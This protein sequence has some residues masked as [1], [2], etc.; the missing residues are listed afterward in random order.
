MSFTF[1]L[2]TL[3]PAAPTLVEKVEQ[4]RKCPADKNQQL[5]REEM[6]TLEEK[7]VKLPGLSVTGSWAFVKPRDF[8]TLQPPAHRGAQGL[9]HI[10]KHAEA[11]ESLNKELNMVKSHYQSSCLLFRIPFSTL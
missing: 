3:R 9:S 5:Y 11:A 2:V 6:Q 1:L 8:L 10:A 7:P 4:K